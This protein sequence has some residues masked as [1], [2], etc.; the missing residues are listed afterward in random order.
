MT[1]DEGPDDIGPLTELRRALAGRGI[2]IDDPAEGEPVYFHG[3]RGAHCELGQRRTGEVVWTCL[4]KAEHLDPGLAVRMAL[5]L[6]AP[7]AAPLPTRELPLPD[8]AGGVLAAAGRVLEAA[9]MTAEP[10]HVSLGDG[11]EDIPALAVVS[12]AEPARGLVRIT[13]EGEF[14]WAFRFAPAD[15]LA[16]GLSPGAVALAIASALE[17][18]P[19][20]A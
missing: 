3:V 1:A 10:V 2:V 16:P 14:L 8:E 17:N 18:A 6:L 9:G 11:S 13:C 4:P 12:S 19:G 15:G 20:G 5:A 7:D